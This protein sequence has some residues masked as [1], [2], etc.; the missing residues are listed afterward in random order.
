[1][2]GDLDT[3]FDGPSKVPEILDQAKKT[4]FGNYPVVIRSTLDTFQDLAGFDPGPWLLKAWAA[5]A[6]DWVNEFGENSEE[7]LRKT[8]RHLQSR[9]LV[10]KSPRSCIVTAH[11][12][13]QG[14]NNHNS[15]RM[16]H[17]FSDQYLPGLDY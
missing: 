14:M 1:M 7:L 8:V 3:F 2:S 4:R 11:H 9:Q 15:E 5:G 17:R 12:L 13:Q 6:H 16:R 10:I